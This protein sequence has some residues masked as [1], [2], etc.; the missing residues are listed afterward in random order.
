ML[1]PFATVSSP[2]EGRAYSERV[3][4][5]LLLSYQTR[6]DL[7]ISGEPC[8]HRRTKPWVEPEITPKLL[9]LAGVEAY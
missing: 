1:D 5:T 3:C 4:S 8:P 9:K 6:T 2:L 7:T